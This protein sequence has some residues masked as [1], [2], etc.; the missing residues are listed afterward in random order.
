MTNTLR[1]PRRAETSR[2]PSGMPTGCSGSKRKNSVSST[3][4]PVSARRSKVSRSSGPSCRMSYGGTPTLGVAVSRIPILR[5]PAAAAT[6]TSSGGVVSSTVRWAR[7]I[8]LGA[9]L[10]LDYALAHRCACVGLHHMIPPRTGPLEDRSRHR[11]MTTTKARRRSEAMKTEHWVYLSVVAIAI[12]LVWAGSVV[13]LCAQQ[14]GSGVVAIDPDEIGGVGTGPKGPEASG[15]GIE[16]TAG[17]RTEFARMVVTDD[18]GR[19]VIPD[20]PK[21]KYR[22]WVRGYGL[23]DSPKIDSQPG[24]Q[25]NL[26]AVTAPDA[27]A[28]AKYYPAIYWYSMLKIPPATEFG[29][30]S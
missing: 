17:H 13:T 19:Y 3:D 14:A 24:K 30:T 21:A 26:R 6:V 12:A 29:G 16:G 2:K 23:V 10:R 22:V 20:L 5:N 15:R 4:T 9:I 8:S 27:A 18:Q 25:L 11:T 28:A 1:A 7:E